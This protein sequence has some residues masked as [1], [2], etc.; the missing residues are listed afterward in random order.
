MLIAQTL[1]GDVPSG[2]AVAQLVLVPK[3]RHDAHVSL[4]DDALIQEQ[5][6]VGLPRKRLHGVGFL[7]CVF[8]LLTEVLYLWTRGLIRNTSGNTRTSCGC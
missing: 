2:H 7:R 3:E 4:D 8:Q 5:H 6:A 1:Y